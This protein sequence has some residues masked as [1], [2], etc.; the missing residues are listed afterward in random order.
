MIHFDDKKSRNTL[1]FIFIDTN[2][3]VYFDSFDTEY[4]PQEVIKKSKI[5][6]SNT[7]YSEY[8]ITNLLCKDFIVSLS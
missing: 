1:G 2:T 3:A 7:I 8:K 5:H 6:L 4:T